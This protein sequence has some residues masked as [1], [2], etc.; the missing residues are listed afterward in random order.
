MKIK[1]SHVGTVNRNLRITWPE[2]WPVLSIDDEVG[3]P[4]LP[5]VTHVRVVEWCPLGNEEDAE[6]FV[7][8]VVGPRRGGSW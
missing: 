1:V 2:G 4:G 5:E 7:Y 3:I 6:P 8:I